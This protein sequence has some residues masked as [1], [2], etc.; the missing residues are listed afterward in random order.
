MMYRQS[1]R[2]AIWN[3]T[4]SPNTSIH[5]WKPPQWQL[6]FLSECVTHIVPCKILMHRLTGQW[7][8]SADFSLDRWPAGQSHVLQIQNLKKSSYHNKTIH[9]LKVIHSAF[10]WSINLNVGKWTL[11]TGDCP[12]V[13]SSCTSLVS[14][15]ICS[16]SWCAK[17]QLHSWSLQ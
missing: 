4:I 12:A 13:S 14:C 17:V 8:E 11:M 6:L 5:F 10:R 3:M 16:W 7:S 1:H 9:Q 15:Q 2:L